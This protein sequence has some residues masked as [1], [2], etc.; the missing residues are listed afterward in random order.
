MALPSPV[1]RQ[2]PADGSSARDGTSQPLP[3][4]A[5]MMSD[6]ACTGILGF[7]EFYESHVIARRP[8]FTALLPPSCSYILYTPFSGLFPEPCW[9][10]Q[11]LFVNQAQV[12][13]SRKAFLTLL[14]C[15]LYL[16]WDTKSYHHLPPY[17]QMIHLLACFPLYK[18]ALKDQRTA[19]LHFLT[20]NVGQ[21]AV[22]HKRDKFSQS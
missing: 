12:I 15:Y 9:V 18:F 6:C 11:C 5:G 19:N 17:I 14:P 10:G 2:L 8:G 3:I 13:V 16:W 21:R 20:L 4:H 22:V 1:S 7:Y